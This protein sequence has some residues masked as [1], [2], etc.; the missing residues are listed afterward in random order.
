MKQMG[1]TAPNIF[2]VSIITNCRVPSNAVNWI[3]FHMLSMLLRRNVKRTVIMKFVT[4]ERNKL[5]FTQLKSYFIYIMDKNWGIELSGI[6]ASDRSVI[7]EKTKSN[8]Y[9]R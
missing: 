8:N 2:V 3:T 6:D 7:N 9:N 1:T 5:H 4:R